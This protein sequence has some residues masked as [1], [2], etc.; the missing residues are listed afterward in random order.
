MAKTIQDKEKFIELRAKGLS[1]DKISKELHVSKPT[2]IE[3]SKDLSEEIQ[4]LKSIENEALQELY[5]VAREKRIEQLA[6]TLDKINKELDKRDLK[7]VPEKDLMTMKLNILSALK[8]EELPVLFSKTEFV[9][10]IELPSIGNY[11]KDNWSA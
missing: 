11:S 7:E 2:L 4:N 5:Y 1:F 8:A 10:G 3:W 9:G 6:S